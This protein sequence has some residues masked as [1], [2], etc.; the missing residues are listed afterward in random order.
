MKISHLDAKILIQL[1]R[2]DGPMTESELAG[3]LSVSEEKLALRMVGLEEQ[4]AVARDNGGWYL[5]DEGKRT[6][7]VC[8]GQFMSALK[9]IEDATAKLAPH[10]AAIDSISKIAM[11][12][13]QIMD[14]I[15]KAAA[16]NK[17]AIDRLLE[18]V[19]PL[20]AK[21]FARISAPFIAQIDL[22]PRY[23]DQIAESANLIA[24]ASH[25]WIALNP[26]G[27]TLDY[28]KLIGPGLEGA[29]QQYVEIGLP[30]LVQNLAPNDDF[31][32]AI[33]AAK[34][35]LEFS[36]PI[37]DS[38]VTQIQEDRPGELV[39]D[40]EALEEFDALYPEALEGYIEAQSESPEAS[41]PEV[42][43]PSDVPPDVPTLGPG[44]VKDLITKAVALK[45]S[46]DLYSMMMEWSASPPEDPF[47]AY[48]LYTSLTGI[49]VWRMSAPPEQE[50]RPLSET[51]S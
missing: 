16:P 6:A 50:D 8:T 12:D 27:S 36:Q 28:S 11:P 26:A 23:H 2:H 46:H 24:K 1:D 33:A 32:G 22:L 7:A 25:K 14:K 18:A 20:R 43:S 47:L 17:D 44:D 34:S 5:T 15:A 37:I 39:L 4:G 3:R 40:A 51:S 29:I 21:D 48:V 30:K 38:V 13:R 31:S 19:P 35:I 42:S 49:L 41:P 45:G 9:T 10:R